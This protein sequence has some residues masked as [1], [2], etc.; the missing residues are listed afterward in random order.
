MAEWR[1]LVDP[2]ADEL[3]AAVGV[4]LPEVRVE[5]LAASPDPGRR[6]RLTG[7]HGRIAGKLQVPVL[8]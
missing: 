8:V 4:L 2:T 5:Q 3:L 1:D 6:P 7:G